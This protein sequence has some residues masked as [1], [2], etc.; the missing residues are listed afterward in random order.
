MKWNFNL[1]T[2]GLDNLR[3]NYSDEELIREIEFQIERADIVIAV[4]TKM[5]EDRYVVVSAS[6]GLEAWELL[7]NNHYRL[8]PVSTVLHAE[9]L[10]LF[11]FCTF[12]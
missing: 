4:A 5:L 1:N 9:S 11:N 3:R 7:Q 8:L 6:N 2:V 12:R 10:W